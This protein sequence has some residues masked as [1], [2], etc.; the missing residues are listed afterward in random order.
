M[1]TIFSK[2]RS[3]CAIAAALLV[4]MGLGVSIVARGAS[5]DACDS[6]IPDISSGYGAD[7]PYAVDVEAV[8]NPAFRRKPVQVFIPKGVDGPR[9]VIFFSHGY[10]PGDWRINADLIDHAVSRGYIV[11]F[12]SYPMVRATMDDR[13]DALWSGFEAATVKFRDRMDLTRVAF[14]GHS[15][16]GGATPAMA[17]RGI[18]QHGW[19]KKGAFLM[20]LAPWYA[21][22]ITNAQLAQFPSNIIQCV[23]AYENDTVN[24]HRMGIDLYANTPVREKFYFLVHSASVEGCPIAADHA[25]PGRNPS[26]RQRQ[27]G[28]FQPLDALCDAAFVGTRQSKECLGLIGLRWSISDRL[29]DPRDMSPAEPVT[30]HNPAPLYR[31]IELVSNPVPIEPE[32]YYRNPWSSDS[33]PRLHR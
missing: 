30:P 27:Y 21:Y 7:G 4:V 12:S 8:D 13:Y 2:R 28:V 32:S 14:V 24:D 1:S 19:G 17:Y 16:G 22:Q 25:T 31:P 5:E 29:P 15:F 9:P 26:H 11:V 33:N 3:K 20:E 6:K 10:G 18:V 23:E